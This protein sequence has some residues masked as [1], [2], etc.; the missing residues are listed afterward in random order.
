MNQ[1]VNSALLACYSRTRERGGLF[2]SFSN[3]LSWN[4]SCT[5]YHFAEAGF[6]PPIPLR[7]VM[8]MYKKICGLLILCDLAG[9][10]RLEFFPKSFPTVYQT[11]SKIYDRPLSTPT[12]CPRG[13]FVARWTRRD[14]TRGLQP[15]VSHYNVSATIEILAAHPER[16]SI[17]EET[18]NGPRK[19]C[20]ETIAPALASAR[21]R[22][23]ARS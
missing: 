10:L 12:L 21:E 18:Y 6:E 11:N 23:R 20:C 22:Q 16:H 13:R 1:L 3:T 2:R 15:G 7:R 14:P 19:N 8:S 9:V 17:R 4:D 5:D